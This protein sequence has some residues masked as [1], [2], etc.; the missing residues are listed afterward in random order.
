MGWFRRGRIGQWRNSPSS[1]TRFR[2]SVEAMEERLTPVI[3]AWDGGSFGTGTNWCDPVNWQGDRLPG[4]NDDAVIGDAFSSRTISVACSVTIQTLQA[5]A[6][7]HVQSETFTLD[8][9]DR[10]EFKNTVRVND[11]AMLVFI[12]SRVTGDT[13]Q[14]VNAGVTEVKCRQFCP[15]VVNLGIPVV[16]HGELR[17]FPGNSFTGEAHKASRGLTNDSGGVLELLEQGALDFTVLENRGDIFTH[18]NSMLGQSLGLLGTLTNHEKTGQITILGTTAL[19][20]R[21]LDNAG[22]VMVRSGNLTFS[23][24]GVG[25]WSIGVENGLSGLMHAEGGGVSFQRG[26]GCTLDSIPFN[27]AGTLRASLS[28]EIAYS[29]D[30]FVNYSATTLSGGTYNLAGTFRFTDANIATN[31]ATILLDGPDS[32]IVNQSNEPGLRNFTT[33]AEAG[34]FTIR[35][36]ANFSTTAFMNAGSVTVEGDTSFIIRDDY[37][38]IA[39]GSTYLAGGNLGTNTTRSVVIAETSYLGGWGT[40]RGDIVNH[41]TL[42]VGGSGSAGQLTILGNY[43]Q[44][45]SGNLVIELGGTSPGI[46][47]DFLDIR[48]EE[49]FAGTATLDGTLTIRLLDGYLPVPNDLFVPF[50]AE[51]GITG[52]FAAF[53]G[54]LLSETLA[55]APFHDGTCYYLW[56]YEL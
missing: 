27:N 22:S 15:S 25:L 49:G 11:G 2:P 48:L 51:G 23:C 55:L 52:G 29:G 44:F 7:L 3:I 36:G 24:F 9:D 16:N 34:V 35:N 38:Q 4:A 40:L 39:G 26:V 8:R 30:Q 21:A 42:D 1:I 56:A 50:C 43:T 37:T 47:H 54:L 33:N 12:G 5:A 19:M 31:A 17:V 6:Q 14:F 28:R 10:S 13:G 53:D 46:D 20:L 45:A 32:G 18:A 41:G